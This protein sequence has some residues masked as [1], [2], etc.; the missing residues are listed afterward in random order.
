[1][2]LISNSAGV[3]PG[4]ILSVWEGDFGGGNSGVLHSRSPN[5]SD[6]RPHRSPAGVDKN[7]EGEDPGTTLSDPK[8]LKIHQWRDGLA[9]S[10]HADSSTGVRASEV[11]R[12]HDNSEIHYHRIWVS[13]RR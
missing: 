10:Q 11:V 2:N 3:V 9:S 1:M 6:W 4:V 12:Y 13:Q 5:S 7:L 8:S